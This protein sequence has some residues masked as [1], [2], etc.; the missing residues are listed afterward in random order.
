MSETKPEIDHNNDAAANQQEMHEQMRVRLAKLKELAAAGRDPF[1]Q[2][3]F[4]VS[5]HSIDIIDNFEA[6]EVSM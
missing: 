6:M 1:E 4:E 5:N 3:Q 2:V